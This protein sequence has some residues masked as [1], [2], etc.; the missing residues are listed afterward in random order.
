MARRTTWES[1]TG[2]KYYALRRSDRNL[3]GKAVLRLRKE[4][5]LTRKEVIARAQVAGWNLSE[6]ALKRIERREREVTDIELVKLAKV[7]RVPVAMLLA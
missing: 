4:A 2:T 6:H 5:K 7:L 1:K 3:I